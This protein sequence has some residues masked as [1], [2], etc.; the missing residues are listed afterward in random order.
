MTLIDNYAATPVCFLRYF[1]DIHDAS[2]CLILSQIKTF[3]LKCD[4]SQVSLSIILFKKNLLEMS[5][6]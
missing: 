6:N 5:G 2:P 4:L 3:H 1:T